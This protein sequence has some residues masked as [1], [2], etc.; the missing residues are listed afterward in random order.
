MLAWSF[1]RYGGAEGLVIPRGV[2]L[3]KRVAE[4]ISNLEVEKGRLTIRR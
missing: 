4:A 3:A 1:D 2:P